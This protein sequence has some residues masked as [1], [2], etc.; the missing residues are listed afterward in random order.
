VP[1]FIDKKEIEQTGFSRGGGDLRETVPA[2]EHIDER[3]LAYIGTANE[4]EFG[5]FGWGAEFFPG[6]RANEIGGSNIQNSVLILV[7]SGQ[8]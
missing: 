8:S 2:G 7:K 4:S 3:G 1:V 5:Q 6:E